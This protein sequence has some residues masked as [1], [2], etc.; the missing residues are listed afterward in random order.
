MISFVVSPFLHVLVSARACACEHVS[1]CVLM[2]AY[3]GLL[4]VA[5]VDD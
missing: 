2:R 5:A 3:V 1:M 4:C